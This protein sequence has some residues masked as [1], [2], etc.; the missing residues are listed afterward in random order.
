MLLKSKLVNKMRTQDVHKMRTQDVHN[1]RTQDVHKMLTNKAGDQKSD[2]SP[3]AVSPFN[4]LQVIYNIVV[5]QT[6]PAATT[7]NRL[8]KF[9]TQCTKCQKR[10][11][12]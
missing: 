5:F 6:T 2:G 1:M 11:R 3:T 7:Y 4:P 8:C 12:H 10:I 9:L